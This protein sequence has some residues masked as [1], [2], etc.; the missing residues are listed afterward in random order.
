MD[1]LALM[2][3]LRG[4]RDVEAAAERTLRALLGLVQ[5]ALTAAAFPN[6]RVLRA[7]LHLR[8]DDGYAGLYV[9]EHEAASLTA[10]G[11]D[12]ALLPSATVWALIRTAGVPV[13]VDVGAQTAQPRGGEA[14]PIEWASRGSTQAS[15]YRLM[16]RQATHLYVLPLH[17]PGRVAGMLSVEATCLEAMGA[18]F[19]W[20]ACG[21]AMERVTVLAGPYLAAL[22]PPV[23][24]G[25]T[26][27]ALLPVVGDRMAALVRVLRAFAAENETLLVRGETGTGKSRLARWIHANSPRR[28]GAFEVLDLLSVPDETQLGELFGWRRGAFT[29][30]VADHPGA[31]SRAEGG[32][33]FIDEVDKLSLRAQAGLL[34]LLEERRYRVLGDRGAPREADVRFVVGTN[35]DLASAVREGRFREDLF[36][37]IN[38]LPVALPPLRERADEIPAWARYMVGRHHADKGRTDP[39][40]LTAEAADALGRHPWPGNLRELDNVVRR[41]YTFAAMEATGAVSVDASHVST[42]MGP[43]LAGGAG[44]DDLVAALADAASALVARLDRGSASVEGVDVPAAFSGLLLAAAIE[45]TG[46]RE[47]GFRLVGRGELIRNRNHHKALKR[48]AARAV[49]LCDALGEPPPPALARLLERLGV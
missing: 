9:L 22:P 41:A 16:Q 32:T 13:A 17:A 48:E 25:A 15:S 36:Y 2:D 39:V 47:D 1:P 43:G 21:D 18:P 44:A 42:A 4:E 28:D 29:G 34:T 8:P 5:D 7:M 38:V 49:E 27:D 19:L 37:R 40:A 24:E 31:V 12:E 6:A 10:P 26:G 46:A 23:R 11:E 30:A 20:P 33:L 45:A 14:R 35:A 3:A